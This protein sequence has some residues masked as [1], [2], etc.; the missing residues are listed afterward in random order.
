MPTRR[1]ILGTSLLAVLCF[2]TAHADTPAPAVQGPWLGVWKLNVEKSQFRTNKPPLGTVRTYTMSAA[3]HDTFDVMILSTSPAGVQ[4]MN[5]ATKGARFDGKPYREVGN[6]FADANSFKLLS[7]RS[8]EFVET[9][10]GAEVITITVDI[11]E[12]G[13]TR[14]S[15]QKSTGADGKQSVNVAVW[16]RQD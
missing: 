1:A 10:N 7:D 6:P 5:M 11:S 12:D 8:Y 15:R 13:R 14:T 2:A 3:G 16:D 4:T 9:K